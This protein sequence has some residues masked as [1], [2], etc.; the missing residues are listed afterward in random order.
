MR[1]EPVYEPQKY[2]YILHIKY[3]AIKFKIYAL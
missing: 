1:S 3:S 2:V